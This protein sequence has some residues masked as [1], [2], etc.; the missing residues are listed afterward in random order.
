M[1]NECKA[2]CE[3]I[4]GERR[5]VFRR[6]VENKVEVFYNRDSYS[7]INKAAIN[8]IINCDNSEWNK[9]RFQ[10]RKHC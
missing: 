7:E 4:A 9:S 10:T 5:C 2:N 6:E 1:R 8:K 3:L